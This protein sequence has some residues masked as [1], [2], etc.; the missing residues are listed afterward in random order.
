MRDIFKQ[1][2]GKKILVV[3][4]VMVDKYVYGQI[5]RISPE[6]PVPIFEIKS[7]RYELGGAANVARNVASLGGVPILIGSWNASDVSGTMLLDILDKHG[8]ESHACAFDP[9]RPTTTKTRY[10]VG[11]QCLFRTDDEI[12]TTFDWT[13]RLKDL[14][15]NRLYEQDIDGVIVSDYDKGVVNRPI[16]EI[17]KTLKVPMIGDPKHLNFWNYLDFDCITPNQSEVERA[18]GTVNLTE[19]VETVFDVL[20]LKYL[21]ITAGSRGIYAGKRGNTHHYPAHDVEVID[22]SGAGD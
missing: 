19:Q 10:F 13:T 21:L 4:D 8:Y 20:H 3:G 2:K 16:L 6:A 12:R 1:I 18:T 15:R 14:L 7:A 11:K 17:L 22:V 5:N 9:A